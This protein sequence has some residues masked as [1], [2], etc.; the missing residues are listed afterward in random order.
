PPRGG[1]H[2]IPADRFLLADGTTCDIIASVTAP[3]SSTCV[4]SRTTADGTWL[5]CLYAARGIDLRD[6]LRRGVSDAELVSLIRETWQGRSDRGAEER[7]GVADRGAL[8]R[9]DSLRADPHREMHTRG[10]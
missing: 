6:P 8:Y 9:I 4:R 7:L 2:R 1:V 10:G 3:F 5:L